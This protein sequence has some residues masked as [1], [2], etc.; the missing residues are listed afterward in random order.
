MDCKWVI[1]A[2]Y[3]KIVKL[4]FTLFDLEPS[5]PISGCTLDYVRVIDGLELSGAVIGEYCGNLGEFTVKSSKRFLTLVF[6][7]NRFLEREGFIADYQMLIAPSK[8]TN[9]GEFA[10]I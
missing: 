8:N 2:I 4:T 7:S 9:E 6:H 10:L 1:S 3:G 5:S